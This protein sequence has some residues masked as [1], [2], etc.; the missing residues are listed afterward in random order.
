MRIETT[1]TCFHHPNR[2]TGRSCTRCGRPACSECLHDAPVGAHCFEC[3]RAARPPTRQRLRRWNAAQGPLATK[4]LI[5]VN[6]V[7]FL[8]TSVSGVQAA[9]RGGDLQTQLSLYGPAVARGEWY[10]LVSSGFV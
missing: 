10:R 6:V 2:E 1:T 8:V 7:V 4:V 9:G 5:A 3:I